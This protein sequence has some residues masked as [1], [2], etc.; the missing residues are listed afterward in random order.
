MLQASVLCHHHLTSLSLALPDAQEDSSQPEPGKHQ[1]VSVLP[2]HC[3]LRDLLNMWGMTLRWSTWE[4]S[5]TAK[6]LQH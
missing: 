3:Q 5:H 1:A 4:K 6:P 2:R